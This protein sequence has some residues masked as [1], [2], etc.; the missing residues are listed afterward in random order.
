MRNGV[1]RRVER[2][3]GADDSE[4]HAD[5]KS[6]AVVLAGLAAKATCS[7]TR[8]VASSADNVSVMIER[9]RSPVA[10]ETV[11][12]ASATMWS[13]KRFLF[14]IKQLGALSQSGGTSMRRRSP[15]VDGLTRGTHGLRYLFLRGLGN[16]GK[17]FAGELVQDRNAGCA[18]HP[19]T[20][21]ERECRR[22]HCVFGKRGTG[23]LLC[24]AHRSQL[25]GLI[26]AFHYWVQ[27]NPSEKMDAGLSWT[28]TRN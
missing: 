9:S 28:S 21:Q 14:L 7:P 6:N 4:R 10:S 26:P 16:F 3:Y 5:S 11:N 20:L 17:Y 12:P 13:M 22:K 2:R 19:F 25:L 23:L 8:R 1:Q 18:L 24:S 27:V 15:G